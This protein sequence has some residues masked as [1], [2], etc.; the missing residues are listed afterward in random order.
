MQA[1]IPPRH[2]DRGFLRG[3][4]KGLFAWTV[5]VLLLLDWLIDARRRWHESGPTPKARG[6]RLLLSGA[7]AAFVFVGIAAARLLIGR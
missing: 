6:S 5:F 2:S 7:A 3:P 1:K 4:S